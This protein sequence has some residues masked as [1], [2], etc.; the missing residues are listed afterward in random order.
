MRR[1]AIVSK[2]RSWRAGVRRAAAKYG[3]RYDGKRPEVV[4][5]FGGDGT[6]LH[7]ERLYPGVPKLP[8]K[9][10]PTCRKCHDHPYEHALD[11]IRRRRYS[12]E[13]SLKLQAIVKRKGRPDI[14]MVCLN[15]FI[16][17]NRNLQ[18][19]IRFS[20]SGGKKHFPLLIGDGVVV[21]TPFG[22]TAYF[23]S[24]TKRS[25]RRGIGIVFNNV[26]LPHRHLILPGSGTVSLKLVR[27]PAEFAADNHRLSGPLWQGDIV[28]I[29]RS[30]Q[31]ATLLRLNA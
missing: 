7:A 17:R 5:T 28:R 26:T 16:L 31:G 22:S 4:L 24:I 13:R 19:A 20:L 2:N 21:C 1:I 8:L 12:K 14:K 6:L 25:F 11:M 10:S 29:C 23:H 9:L 3:F 30:R 27:G 18:H 15:D